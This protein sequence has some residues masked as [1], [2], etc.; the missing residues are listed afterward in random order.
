MK[1]LFIAF[2][3][4]G[5]AA[6]TASAATEIVLRDEVAMESY[7]VRLGDV[8]EISSS[9]A[10]ESQRLTALPLM[11]APAAGDRRFLRKRQI[12]DMLMAHGIDLSSLTVS[13][14][15]QVTILGTKGEMPQHDISGPSSTSAIVATHKNRRAALLAGDLTSQTAPRLEPN[16]VARL[17][18]EVREL[19]AG[20]LDTQTGRAMD[21]AVTCEIADRHLML[22]AAATSPLECQGGAAPWT[23][24]QRFEI[25]FATTEGPVNVPVYADVTPESMPVVVTTRAMTRGDV[26]TAADLDLQNVAYESKPGDRRVA[27]DAVETLIGMEVRRPMPAG[28]IVF[29]DAVQSPI[30]VKRGDL[31]TVTSQSSGIRVQITAKALQ[32]RSQGELV[33]VESLDT[34]AKFDA[35]VVGLREASIVAI[36]PAAIGGQVS[37]TETA[38]R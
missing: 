9:D 3:V 27:L 38:R 15:A 13:G 6:S 1:K 14:A 4:I 28:S 36:G 20:H 19:I 25:S 12:E 11:P 34:K 10:R 18:G 5:L 37:Q 29:S 33:Q 16:V 24:R 31:I 2:V 7:V 8:A 30:L 22:L 32:D 23:G 17:N 35:R 21:V 26:F